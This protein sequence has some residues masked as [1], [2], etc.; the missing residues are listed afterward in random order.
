MTTKAAKIQLAEALAEKAKRL[1][2]GKLSRLYQGLYPWQRN[3]IAATATND[4]SMLMA[5]NQC[6]AGNTLVFIRTEKGQQWVPILE[7]LSLPDAS[8]MT[9]ADGSTHVSDSWSACFQGIL[10]T[11]RLHL[12]NGRFLDCTGEHKVLDAEG[13]YR[14]ILSLMYG[15]D[16]L[17][18]SHRC[19]DCLA[20]CAED[21]C[22]CGQPLPQAPNN[23]QERPQELIDALQRIQ[24]D[25]L[26][27]GA[28]AHIDPR[29]LACLSG[30]LR[31][32][33]DAVRQLSAL[34]DTFSCRIASMPAELK[35]GSPEGFQQPDPVLVAGPQEALSAC[36]CRTPGCGV[37]Y[38][39]H[40]YVSRA[41]P[42]ANG[43]SII[44]WQGI[45]LQPCFD[46]I[47]PDSNNYLTE[48]VVSHNCGKTRTGTAID[49]FHLTGDYPED[50]EGHKF[51]HAPMCWL[52][53]YSGEKTRDLLQTKLFGRL[54]GQQ[55][56][57]G[58]I[59]AD[60]IVDYKSMSG[61]TGACRE[62]RVRHISGGIS[63]CQFWSYSQGQHALM[64]DVVD[65]YHIDEEPEDDEIYPQLVTRTANG[66][67]GRGGRGILTFTPENGKTQ[68]VC[69]FMETPEPGMYLQGATWDECPHMSPEKKA[70]LLSKYPAH[71]REM[72]SKGTPLM[73]SGLIYPVDEEAIKIAPFSI[74]EYWFVINGMDFGWDHP[75]AHVQVVWDRDNDVLYV[76]NAWKGSQ[77]QPYEAWHIVKRWA[78]DIPTAWPNDG[79]QTRQQMGKQDA[80][81]QKTLYEN[82]GWWMLNE[83]ACFPD[84]SVGVWSGITTILD[85]MNTGRLRV[86]SNLVELLQEIRE[87]HTKT[88]ADGNAVIVKVKDDLLDALRYSIMMRRHAI[89]IMD[90]NDQYQNTVSN[91]RATAGAYDSF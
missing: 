32:M 24:S 83:G 66:D 2:R 43:I 33:P 60:M 70:Q 7:F 11:Y 90:I 41:I 22:R 61:T 29:N 13:N 35:C 20:N 15:L 48:G 69:Q 57:G 9:W 73:G 67:R 26:R 30:D 39:N 38:S 74:P 88:T 19:G 71:Q 87:Y 18:L 4:A 89:R 23:G 86:F 40:M 50:W 72:R 64:G 81:Q 46:L 84:G 77:K 75:Q 63:V 54:T 37:A 45:G 79:L 21:G 56:E 28:G 10:P 53:G 6:V 91:Q 44:A 42:L 17:H 3:F 62:V 80:V 1:E 51:D 27:A 49:A 47:V 14:T 25:S 5:S 31:S 12:S 65:W 85:Y 58:L 55:F 76:T 59:P 82:E 78:A 52:L 34:C 36:S 16:A 8:V 68:L